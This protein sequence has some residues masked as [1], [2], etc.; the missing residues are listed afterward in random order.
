MTVGTGDPA[1]GLGFGDLD[2]AAGSAVPV[3]ITAGSQVERET[4]ARLI[5]RNGIQQQH[6]FIT[7][8]CNSDPNDPDGAD[9]LSHEDGL[10]HLRLAEARG[11]TLFV[12]DIGEMTSPLQTQLLA[13][14]GS[15]GLNARIIAGTSRPLLDDIA[16]GTFNEALFYRLNVIHLS[17]ETSGRTALE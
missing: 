3:L 7:F 6:P 15:G 13:L 5:H 8:R 14:M 12:D 16:A 2:L 17:F 10:L 1:D 4:C 11:G 9:R